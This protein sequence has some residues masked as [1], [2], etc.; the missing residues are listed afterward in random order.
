MFD[1]WLRAAIGRRGVKAVD[2][3]LACAVKEPTV[4]RWLNGSAMP[5]R[6]QVASLSAF[7]E[8]DPATILYMTDPDIMRRTEAEIEQR[9]QEAALS[10]IPELHE[11][12]DLLKKMPSA[13]RA[14]LIVIARDLASAGE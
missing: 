2:V 8:V 10:G 12:A 6:R 4:S 14:A 13:S 7:L 5:E 3:A 1:A 9:G 11:F